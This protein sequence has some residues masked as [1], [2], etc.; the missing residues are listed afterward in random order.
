MGSSFSLNFHSSFEKR[1]IQ[2]NNEIYI[3]TINFK[4]LGPG[5]VER[6]CPSGIAAPYLLEFKIP[7]FYVQSSNMVGAPS[8]EGSRDSAILHELNFPYLGG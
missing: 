8:L 1:I 3:A 5:Y 7:S 4:Y 2:A 6:G